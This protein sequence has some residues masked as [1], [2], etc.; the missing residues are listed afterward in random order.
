M[1]VA[2]NLVWFRVLR[3]LGL[4]DKFLDYIQID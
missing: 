1:I 3:V 2:M 4:M